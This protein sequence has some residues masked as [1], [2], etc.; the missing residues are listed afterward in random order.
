MARGVAVRCPGGSTGSDGGWTVGA[1]PCWGWE[2][3]SDS[4]LVY[5]K[6]LNEAVD[7]MQ[8]AS[9]Q[10]AVRDEC[11]YNTISSL[12]VSQPHPLH[13]HCLR[14]REIGIVSSPSDTSYSCRAVRFRMSVKFL[15]ASAIG[16]YQKSPLTSRSC[17]ECKLRTG[18]SESNPCGSF[19]QRTYWQ[20]AKSITEIEN[21]TLLK[22]EK[23]FD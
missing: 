19:W 10:T 8:Y 12:V 2:T 4:H 23:W 22:P 5:C 14:T 9:S 16:T 13:M 18:L 20:L 21:V 6:Y 7:F 11:D 17:Q 15:S 1:I 3:N